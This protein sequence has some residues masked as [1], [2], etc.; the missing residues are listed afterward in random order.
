MEATSRVEG[1]W[2]GR[3]GAQPW[4][5]VGRWV[6]ELAGGFTECPIR[7][8]AS[9]LKPLSFSLSLSS[10]SSF[11]NS[12]PTLFWTLWKIQ[13][14]Q[15]VWGA[16]GENLFETPFLN[17]RFECSL[18]WKV[19][20]PFFSAAFLIC[21]IRAKFVW[22][23]AWEWSHLKSKMMKE[24]T[25]IGI[26]A[27]VQLQNL[28][29]LLKYPLLIRHIQ[30]SAIASLWN[31]EQCQGL[32][33]ISSWLKMETLSLKPWWPGPQAQCQAWRLQPCTR[34]LS[35]PSVPLGEARHPLQSRQTQVA[36]A[37]PLLSDCDL[38]H[39]HWGCKYRV[40]FCVTWVLKIRA[41]KWKLQTM[42]LGNSAFCGGS[43]I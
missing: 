12:L 32:P 20:L 41:H 33:V 10:Q 11:L 37:H 25:L 42:F 16:P 39:L 29:Q 30:N 40:V 43:S 38:N 2:A 36:D 14:V 4:G 26:L 35:D 15:I 22:R 7:A 34:S 5:R 23:M 8:E 9:G 31:G 17:K 28:F 13:K 1:D 3:S 18:F 19:A 6:P 27:N 24:V 21:K